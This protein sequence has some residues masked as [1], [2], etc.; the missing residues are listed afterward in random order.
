MTRATWFPVK[1]DLSKKRKTLIG[2]LSFIVPLGLWCAISYLP[3]LWHPKVEVTDRGSISFLKVG[4]LVDKQDFENFNTEAV[5]S[6]KEP[7]KGFRSNPIYLPGPDEVI[8][9]FFNSLLKPPT[10]EGD[11][12]VYQALIHSIMIISYGFIISSLIGVPLGIVCGIFNFYS[13]LFEPF[14][15]FFRYLPAPAFGAL[16]VAIL[17]INDA[18]KIAIII[19][20]TLPQQILVIANTTRKLE[21]SILEA[22]QTLGANRFQL[23]T[24]VVIPGSMPDVFRNQRILLG[25][26]WTYLIIAEIVGVKS[27]ITRVIYDQAKYRNF[28]NVYAAIIMIGIIGFSSDRFLGWIENQLFPWKTGKK[29]RFIDFMKK[30][31]GPKDEMIFQAKDKLEAK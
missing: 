27:G 21:D 26:A 1:K 18:P 5:S 28:E 20:G 3:F 23:I 15:E 12:W 4:D 30:L 31:F 17:G 25:W 14:I 29:S 7:A 11:P 2:I 10:R 8:K 22:A 19:I 6:G 9:A 24:R 13:R 16:A